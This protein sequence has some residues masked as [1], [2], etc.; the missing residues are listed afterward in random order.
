MVA[1]QLTGTDPTGPPGDGDEPYRALEDFLRQE[2]FPGASEVRIAEVERPR[3]GMSWETF[4]LRL[5]VI[6]PGP[7]S[8]HRVVVKRA[9][10]AVGPLGPFDAAKDAVI[11]RSLYGHVPVPRLLA[12]TTDPVVFRRPFTVTSYVDGE[13]DDL[14]RVEQWATWQRHRTLLGHRILGV[15]A[16]MRR[17]DWRSGDLASVLGPRGDSRLR[18][19]AMVDWYAQPYREHDGPVTAAQVFWTDVADWLTEHVP[20]LDEQDLVVS[21]GDFRFGNMIWRGTDV[22]AVVDWE[23]AGLSDPMS[24]LGFLAMPMARRRRPELMGMA[25]PLPEL[26]SGYHRATGQAV[27]LR[28]FQ[29]YVIFWQFIEGSLMSRPVRA[30][31]SQTLRTGGTDNAARRSELGQL[32]LGPN[33]HIRQTAPIIEAFEEGRHD[34]V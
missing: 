15:L 2:A 25:L 19:R 9:P 1:G 21:H 32:P 29:F 8:D 26:L 13:S 30:D 6:G 22:A 10:G 14:Y 12:S 16:A 20:A 5:Q 33:L 27:D 18:V 17:Y 31:G 24:D 7:G 3:G 28:S 11:F 34:V 23:R 4:F